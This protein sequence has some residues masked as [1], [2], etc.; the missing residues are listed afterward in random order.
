M[1]AIACNDVGN[2]VREAPEKRGELERLGVKAR[3]MELMGEGDEA[4][5]WEALKCVGGWLK[6]SFDG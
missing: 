4:V 3:V 5:R 6:Y 2:L 1:L